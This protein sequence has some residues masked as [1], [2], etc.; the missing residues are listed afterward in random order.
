M[1]V[2]IID[3]AFSDHT[4]EVYAAI[5]QAHNDFGVSPSYIEIQ[6]ACHISA[7]TVRKAISALKKAGLIIAP[8]FQV[9]SIKPTDPERV[10]LNR[11]PKPWDELA[12]EKK[13]FKEGNK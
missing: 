7:P 13:Y 12:P 1:T 11:K 2:T 3:P 6:Y 9:R 5:R 10:V 4:I 8:K